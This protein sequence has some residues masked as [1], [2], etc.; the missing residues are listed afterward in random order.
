MTKEQ[1][2]IAIAEA[3]GWSKPRKARLQGRPVTY[4]LPP[5]SSYMDSRIYEQQL[6]DYLNDLNAMH[7]AEKKLSNE[8]KEAYAVTL[9]NICGNVPFWFGIAHATTAQRTEAFLKTLNLWE[10]D[11]EK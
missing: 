3:C 8:K 2:R 7:E 10:E 11:N 1:Q 9:H 6:P 4:W 5:D